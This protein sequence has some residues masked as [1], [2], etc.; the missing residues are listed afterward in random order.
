MNPKNKTF[1]LKVTSKDVA[2]LVGVSQST[3]S[4]VLNTNGE[5]NFISKETA[6]RVR[7]AAEQLG[8]SP[9]P[10]ARALRGEKTN[11]IG[12]V[13]REISDPF[14]A[15]LIE[16]ISFEAKARGLN[17]VLGHVHGDPYEGLK[18]AHV[19]DSRQCD[20]MVFVG[21]LRDDQ[22]VLQTVVRE[23]R[24]VVTLCRGK[25]D[26]NVPVVNC[27]NSA[28]VRVILEHLL[29]NQHKYITFVD[30]G[31]FGDIRERRD[32]FLAYKQQHELD[33]LN[34]IQAEENSFGGG[35]RV[36]QN[37]LSLSQRPTAVM[38]ADDAMAI[39]I[40]K[41]IHDA[42]LRIPQ[43]ISIVGFDDIPIA[44]YTYPSL[45]TVRQPIEKM[46]KRA[47]EILIDQISHITPETG[48]M[49]ELLMPELVIRESSGT[50]PQGQELNH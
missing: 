48:T 36:M 20:G 14:F 46:A 33:A 43:D 40:I 12:L 25:R 41:A 24:P 38:A 42:G 45:T 30:G 39:G 34:W 26:A 37:L 23:K 50:A 31:W 17:V 29:S 5:S 4:R 28:G 2:A 8:Y 16:A 18:L 11:L 35:Y 10:I 47:L 49:V 15:G 22:G 7:A 3:V 13:V 1:S 32:S 9:N 44:Q 19:L 6:D 21:D 27:D